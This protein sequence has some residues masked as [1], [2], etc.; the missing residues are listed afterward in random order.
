MIKFD[1]PEDYPDITP[2]PTYARSMT[3]FTPISETRKAQVRQEIDAHADGNIPLGQMLRTEYA[4]GVA[5]NS[6]EN[7]MHFTDV[8]RWMT[9]DPVY[10]KLVLRSLETDITLRESL[11]RAVRGEATP[12][13]KMQLLQE[14]PGYEA[15][16]FSRRSFSLDPEA[17]A[18]D[19]MMLAEAQL[20]MLLRGGEIYDPPRQVRKPK[21]R[22]VEALLT[23][24]IPRK[25][26]VIFTTKQD[27]G[28]LPMQNSDEGITVRLREKYLATI[29]DIQMQDFI[30]TM[31]KQQKDPY[32]FRHGL[33][34]LQ[35]SEMFINY[36]QTL[37]GRSDTQRLSSI[38]YGSTNEMN[39]L[40]GVSLGEFK[41]AAD[42]IVRE[43]QLQAINNPPYEQT[44]V[45]DA[46]ISAAAMEIN[47]Y[48]ANMQTLP[49]I[50]SL[51]MQTQH[52]SVLN[53]VVIAAFIRAY[54]NAR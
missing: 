17:M 26:A 7:I 48:I 8:L 41:N 38:I 33:L 12:Q 44:V 23:E 11:Y 32:D 54:R 40:E 24:N 20:A 1:V 39:R 36:C 25:S 21:L 45:S 19:D 31:R 52:D 37:V 28:R 15:S 6:A 42:A 30:Y 5:A 18:A 46:E 43:S 22:A 14:L 3:S 35:K 27:I 49:D 50:V 51:D 16:E 13:Q 9:R 34:E 2:E 4:E 29:D 47:E 10:R 53:E